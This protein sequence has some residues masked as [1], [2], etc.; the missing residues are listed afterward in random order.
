MR[1]LKLQLL[2]IVNVV[3]CVTY[4]CTGNNNQFPNW[5]LNPQQNPNLCEGW[6][7]ETVPNVIFVGYY[8]FPILEIGIV[9]KLGFDVSAMGICWELAENS[10]TNSLN[11]DETRETVPTFPNWVLCFNCGNLLETSRKFP[12]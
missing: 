6:E 3:S 4:S 2:K 7:S 12:N 10:Q 8:W 9:P 5:E 11:W 1:T